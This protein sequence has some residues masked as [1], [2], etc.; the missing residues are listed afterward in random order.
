MTFHILSLGSWAEMIAQKIPVWTLRVHLIKN[1]SISNLDT[2]HLTSLLDKKKKK[3]SNW[4]NYSLFYRCNMIL[5]IL[6]LFS[7]FLKASKKKKKKEKKPHSNWTSTTE[8]VIFCKKFLQVCIWASE[9]KKNSEQSRTLEIK[10]S[11]TVILVLAYWR[12][13]FLNTIKQPF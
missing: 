2:L 8:H 1:L 10:D 11:F 6:P 3:V 12:T 7:N 9:K 4:H 5:S 13:H